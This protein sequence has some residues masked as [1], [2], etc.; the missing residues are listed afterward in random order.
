MLVRLLNGIVQCLTVPGITDVF[1]MAHFFVEA[2]KMLLKNWRKAVHLR[3]IR[4][5][6]NNSAYQK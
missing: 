4:T 5:C 6:Q 1:K 3:Q 2:G